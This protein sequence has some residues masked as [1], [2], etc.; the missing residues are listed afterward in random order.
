M[1]PKGQSLS[2]GPMSEDAK[3]ITQHLEEAYFWDIT[4]EDYSHKGMSCLQ[5]PF[6][7]ETNAII[8]ILREQS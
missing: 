6:I 1:A 5:Y 2:C 8:S 3:D 7:L 4:A